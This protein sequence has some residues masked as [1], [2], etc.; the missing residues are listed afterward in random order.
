[1]ILG[2]AAVLAALP[3][4]WCTLP[5]TSRS[6]PFVAAGGLGASLVFAVWIAVRAA[7]DGSVV[8]ISHWISVDAFGALMVLMIS[9]VSWAAT[10][11]SIADIAR[12]NP[13]AVR[14]RIYY[15]SLSLLT[16]SMLLAAI[17]VEP[18]IAWIAVEL[19]TLFC[20]LSISYTGTREALEAAWKYMTVSLFGSAAAILG[21]L[22]LYWAAHAAGNAPF[23]YGGLASEIPSL[24]PALVA[25]AFAL[26]LVGF[27]ATVGLFPMHTWMP[28]AHRHAP[29]PICAMISGI[30]TTVA[31]SVLLRLSPV[32]LGTSGVHAGLWFAIFGI[33]SVAAAALLSLHARDMK[34]L[35]AFSTVQNMG[36]VLLAVSLA[37]P[38]GNLGAV[39]QMLA[40][41]ISKSLCFFAAGSIAAR[42]RAPIP[43]GAMLAG[44]LAIAGAPPFALF[45]SEIAI[46]LA[47]IYAGQVWLAAALLLFVGV[48]FSGIVPKVVRV[49]FGQIKTHEAMP[50]AAT[51]LVAAAV[52]LATLVPALLFGLWIPSGLAGL[53]TQAASQMASP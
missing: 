49:V 13:A 10:L 5:R 27:G 24:N 20:A 41:T 14:V 16:A 22:V 18:I 23:T 19:T 48:A 39:W 43:A 38:A 2:A 50:V 42:V 4:L 9:A 15:A 52:I 29:A 28:D 32:F 31:L 47:A 21:L 11:Y 34:R 53:L 7:N 37:T 33:S 36:I 30:Q 25:V 26:L 3:A 8:A 40:H 12:L 46:A 44:A 6:A 51:P 45:L 1:M 17:S 35:F